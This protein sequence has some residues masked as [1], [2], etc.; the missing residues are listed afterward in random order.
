MNETKISLPIGTD[1]RK[2]AYNSND[3]K[4]KKILNERNYTRLNEFRCDNNLDQ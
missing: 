4:L 2:T 1:N 3:Q